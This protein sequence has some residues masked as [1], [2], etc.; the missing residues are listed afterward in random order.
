MHHPRYRPAHH[1]G[2]SSN[3]TNSTDFSA[4][5]TLA[6]YPPYPHWHTTHANT[7]PTPPTLP[8]QSHHPCQHATHAGTNSRP[9]LKLFSNAYQIVTENFLKE[10]LSSKN[11]PIE[12]LLLD[13]KVHEEIC[14]YQTYPQ[15]FAA[16]LAE[17]FYLYPIHHPFQMC[18][19]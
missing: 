13:N 4:P 14:P 16:T 6:H 12:N 3:I 19:F 1:P 9:Y 11:L 18:I 8:T 10:N 15:K 17:L 2:I 5:T 7:L